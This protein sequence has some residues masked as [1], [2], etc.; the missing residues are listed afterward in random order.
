MRQ[1]T[2]VRVGQDR[3]YDR[4]AL[5]RLARAA[6]AEIVRLETATPAQVREKLGLSRKY[7]IPL[8]E[9][10]DLKGF[11]LRGGE[12]RQVTKLGRQYLGSEA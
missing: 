6:L 5:E 1:G 7:L 9:W 3:Y 12:G 2:A 10:L 8:L 4:E 11:T